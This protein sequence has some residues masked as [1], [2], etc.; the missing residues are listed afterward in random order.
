MKKIT[1]IILIAAVF[2][3]A[4]ASEGSSWQPRQAPLMTRWAA[5]VSPSNALPDYPRPQL[6]RSDWT[7]LNGL[8]DYTITPNSSNGVPTFSR[9]ILV[10]FPVESALSGVMAHLDE[11][12][13]LW[14]HRTLSVPDSW[15]GKRV[16]LHFGAVDWRC[17]VWVNGH[18]VGQHE[19]GYDPF[20]FDITDALRLNGAE[21]I[22]VAVTDPTDNGDEPRGKQSRKPEGIFYTPTSGIWQTIWLEPVPQV[23]I[24]GVKTVPDVDS[25]SLHFRVAVNNFSDGLQVEADAF[26]DGREVA[27]VTGSPNTELILSL[28][29]PHLWSPQDPFLYDLKVTLKD[30]DKTLDSISSYFGMRKIALAKDDQGVTRI[31][32]ND[33]FIF[34][35]GVLDQGFWPDGIYTAPTDEAM[36]WDIEFLKK[37]GFNLIRKHVKVEPDRWYY[38]CD[39]LGMLVWQDMPSANNATSDG[40]RDFESELLHMIDNLNNH[41]SIITWVLFNEGWGQYDTESLAK[42][43]KQ[44]DPSRLVDDA[45]GWT[46]MRVGDLVDMHSYPGPDAPEPDI[47]RAAVLGEYGGFG[48]VVPGHIWST[49]FWGYVMVTNRQDLETRYTSM[50]NQVWKLHK[51]RGLNAAVYTQNSDVETECNGLQTYDRAIAKISPSVLLAANSGGFWG[52]SIKVILPNALF[53]RSEWKYTTKEPA[54]NW[55]EP[56]FDASSWKDGI[57]GFGTTG[58]PAIYLNTTWN[59]SDIW[60][61]QNFTLKLEDIPRIELQIFHDEDAEIYFNGV[62]ALK[63][64]GYLTDYDEFEASREALAALHPGENAIAVHCHQTTGGQG[65][66]VGVFTVQ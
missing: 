58:T 13:K 2:I 34:Q 40:R 14:Y 50:L 15:R 20:T 61:R 36:R 31:T 42:W 16:R 7:N 55:F 44:M 10:P 32:L 43:I 27:S 59:S 1:A 60:L 37:G 23:C 51:L 6:V 9:K 39:K 4:H 56:Q 24:D 41:P 25:K 21:D 48:F 49:N 64:S 5:D 35:V 19:G 47:H 53:G 52:R 45:S 33:R 46:D 17:E 38:W 12:S 29:D 65:I 62:S 63:L 57:A 18:N 8:W 11:Q 28:P 3:H 22:V 54:D 66:D 30:G 26:A